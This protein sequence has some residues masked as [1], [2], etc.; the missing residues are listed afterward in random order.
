MIIFLTGEHILSSHH[1][2]MENSGAL[3]SVQWCQTLFTQGYSS[4]S[5]MY[6]VHLRNA[7][8]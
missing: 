3:N 8:I 6:H 4:Q 7:E 2:V 5:K 1:H